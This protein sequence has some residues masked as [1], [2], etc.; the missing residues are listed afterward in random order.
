M[1]QRNRIRTKQD[2]GSLGIASVSDFRLGRGGG[3]AQQIQRGLDRGSHKVRCYKFDDDY[4]GY[5]ETNDDGQAS[6][7]GMFPLL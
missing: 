1:S 2:L 7:L 6:R 3:G 5:N 4:E